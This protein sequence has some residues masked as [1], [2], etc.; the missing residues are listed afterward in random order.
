MQLPDTLRRAKKALLE[1][2]WEEA[3]QL[4]Q[5]ALDRSPN[6]PR[7]VEG[8]RDVHRVMDKAADIESRIAAADALFAQGDYRSVELE[9]IGILDYAVAFPRILKFHPALEQK[10]NQAKDLRIWQERV[11]KALFEIQ[12]LSN[13]DD[14]ENA[15][16]AAETMLLQL[17]QDPAYQPLKDALESARTA[18]FSQ[19]NDKELLHKAQE[20]LR[21]QDYAQGIALLENISE[22]SPSYPTAQ[23]WLKQVRGY[24]EK[25]KRDLAAVETA[26]T[27]SRWADALAQL[28]QWRGSYQDVPLWQ[29]LYLKAGMTY[30]RLKLE[31]GR[32][33]NQQRAF[34]PARHQFESAQIFFEKVLEIYPSHLDA[35]ALRSECGDLVAITTHQ[36]QAQAD[37]D[38]GRREDAA[39][40][41]KLAQQ[42]LAHAKFE[43][44][45]YTAVGAVVETMHNTFQAEVERICEDERRL[46]NAESLWENNHLS[47]A[48]QYFIETM[49]AL[50]P[51]HQ[52]QAAEGLRRVEARI[53]QSEALMARGSAAEDPLA[54]VDAYQDAYDL[55]SEGPGIS[56]VLEYALVK[57]CQHELEA[58]RL[59]EAAGY[60]NRALLLNPD[61]R[62]A[63]S[64]VAKV[65]VKP[66]V[67][68]TLRRITGE[69]EA[70]QRK[71]SIESVALEPLIQDLEAALRKV[72]EWPDLRADLE[73][74][75]KTL[76]NTRASWQQY[77]QSYTH[78]VQLRDKSK[79][80]EALTT[81]EQA[82]AALGDAVPAGVRKQLSDWRE[83]VEVLGRV[84]R[85]ANTA[86]E[87][88]QTAYA[89]TTKDIALSA[90]ADA[91]DAI[92]QYL[93]PVRTLMES[94]ER[95]AAAT[96]GLLS[97][98]L[99]ILQKQLQDL[100]ERAVFASDA[101]ET[102]STFDGLLKIQEIIRMR[103]SDSTL[104]ITRAQLTK[105][106]RESIRVIKQQ[107]QTALQAG[108]LVEAEEKLRQIRELDSADVENIQLYAEIRQRRVLEEQLRSIEREADDRLAGNSPVDAM[109]TLRQGLN[110]LLE[111][112]VNLPPQVRE[113][114]N[115]LTTMGD[116]DDGLALSQ[117]E[118]WQTAQ[119]RLV[120]LGNLRQENW[121]AGRAVFLVD[122]WI[123]LARD[124]ALRGTVASAVQLGNL[125]EAYRAAAAYI[126]SHPTE[127]LA[128]EQLTQC[129]HAL[130]SRANESADKRLQRAQR[131][132]EDG[133]YENALQNLYDIETDFYYPIEQ[134]FPGL[135]DGWDYIQQTRKKIRQ[136]QAEAEKLRTIHA[137]VEPHLEAARQAYLNSAWTE[138][139]H[140]LDMLPY[141]QNV[142]RLVEQV[143]TLR[144]QIAQAW[145]GDVRRRLQEVMNRTETGRQL[146]TTPEQF[147]AFLQEL[148]DLPAQ[149][150]W[151]MLPDE[152]RNAYTWFV[153]QVAQQRDD[154]FAVNAWEQ[155]AMTYLN[156]HRHVDALHALERAL[157]AVRDVKKR[158]A[159]ET[160]RNE[161][162][163]LAQAQ[164]EREALVKQ[165]VEQFD[166]E[167]YAQARQ[168]FENAQRMGADV[169][170]WLAAARAGTLLQNARRLWEESH[171]SEGTLTGLTTLAELVQGNSYA[172]WIA[173]DAQFLQRRVESAQKVPTPLDP[174]AQ[175]ALRDIRIQEA[176]ALRA[177]WET[178]DYLR[179][180]ACDA[181][182]ERVCELAKFVLTMPGYENDVQ[183]QVLLDWVTQEQSF[184]GRA[185]RF[186]IQAWYDVRPLANDAWLLSPQGIE[187]PQRHYGE[188][189]LRLLAG[190]APTGD[191]FSAVYSAVCNH[192]GASNANMAHRIA[193]VVS[194]KIPAPGVGFRFHEILQES[195]LAIVTLDS[196]CFHQVTPD[197][198]ANDVL[199]AEIHPAIGQEDLYAISSPVSDDLSFFG[200][201]QVLQTLIDCL[202]VGQMVGLF[203]LRKVGKTSLLQRL[204]RRLA[205]RRAVA[206]VDI[207]ETAQESGVWPLYLNIIEMFVAEVHR[208]RSDITL[209]PLH[210]YPF[211][212][213]ITPEV[214]TFFLDDLAALYMTLGSPSEHNRLLLIIDEIDKLLPFENISG[215]AGFST[216]LGQL[217]AAHQHKQI[218]DVL[219]VGVNASL[220]RIERWDVRDNEFYRALR[221]VWMPPMSSEDVQKMITS[222]GS[223]MGVKYTPEALDILITEGGGHPYVTRQLCSRAIAGRFGD[224]I[225]E[226]TAEEASVAVEEFV[227]HDEYLSELW[228]K[229]LNER[230]QAILRLLAQAVE[231]AS[232]TQLL[233][234]KQRR[235]ASTDLNALENYRLVRRDGKS[236][237]IGWNIFRKWI[238]WEELGLED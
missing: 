81:L 6:D 53:R 82:I 207:Q 69:W 216:L 185:R 89:D 238:R 66:Q 3:R 157:S 232:R 52:R 218:L 195:G 59:T 200:R 201:E 135:L 188:I 197:Y 91:L 44:R 61:N 158:V 80:A 176:Q 51:E 76:R 12:R 101:I 34:D 115:E 152:D 71:D 173:E 186:F 177:Q 30:G 205:L 49:D 124:N 165:G 143:E 145:T 46:R 184:F 225:L 168:I 215:Y 38:N 68:A 54:A 172:R 230:Q 120:V 122:Q 85:E 154:L 103:G 237:T 134:E 228:A 102:L 114:L 100:D 19:G 142:P 204:Q 191:D 48:R 190:K 22:N 4:Y 213:E 130:I 111:P 15:I 2:D 162:E 182:L 138:A 136:L 107:A 179:D 110:A 160:R 236:Y 13:A 169:T 116:R 105:R 131:A 192:Y 193:L 97:D 223:R 67:E 112:D 132:L 139:E 178:S 233:P 119:D 5:E 206:T 133:D 113:I 214:A 227:S 43:G 231:P 98:D 75:H 224:S 147:D 217:R 35:Q 20:F 96:G 127:A 84:R 163:R 161:V 226:I 118:N 175:A 1:G 199:S 83:T 23:P 125:L 202:D 70:L 155:Q 32:Q 28:E 141:L 180:K 17:P 27:E 24:L 189:Y 210:L 174:A 11:R 94:A 33:L 88:A 56:M 128:V 146:A 86:L 79:W 64:Y 121:A 211:L 47:E 151:R 73:A 93:E 58:G 104:E 187:H 219:V 109:K 196:A 65:G 9:Y 74:L 150:D 36:A 77:E 144:R 123:R 10:Y 78:A 108:D 60:G 25:Q 164:Q 220:N 41:L 72:A 99:L 37:W 166:K 183:A 16:Q 40:A 148:K 194:D 63:R 90:I 221:E 31:E 57:A 203:G 170:E 42:R 18:A 92:H 167:E 117:P 55:W 212:G 106:A 39:Q 235:V 14:W 159:L 29:Q 21:V 137:E 26:M 50:L 45:D 8:L 149:P 198:T 126:K 7:A 129:T 62:E 156:Q 87:K 208:L 181:D 222:L 95:Q 140:T 209:P 153:S 229:R 171:D 234:N